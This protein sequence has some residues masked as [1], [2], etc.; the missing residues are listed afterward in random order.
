MN[1]LYL[2]IGSDKAGTVSIANMVN[3][4]KELLYK[5][6]I[7]SPTRNCLYLFDYLESKNKIHKRKIFTENVE[8][9][10]LETENF[11]SKYRYNSLNNM[12]ILLTTE[13]LWGRLSKNR[14]HDMDKLNIYLNSIKN[15][16]INH[17]IIIILNLRRI[18]LY[19]ES[20]YKQSIK[21]GNNIDI[22]KISNKISPDNAFNFFNAI[23]KVFSKNN[24]LVRP[25]EKNQMYNKDVV[26]DILYIMGLHNNIN[27]FN[28]IHGNEGLHR[29]LLETLRITNEKY[30][31]LL[32]NIDLINI[33]KKLYKE[34]EFTDYKYILNQ[35]S[36]TKLIEQWK[37]F[38]N[39]IETNYN[40]NKLFNDP[41]PEDTHVQYEL[42][43]NKYEIIV[44]LMLN[45]AKV[46]S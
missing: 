38:Y 35:E 11:M 22:N 27:D 21:S 41:L 37:N 6:N 28:I 20:L 19:I 45:E 33:S 15:L 9:R 2:R 5:N 18:D 16:F 1:K 25:F 29:D 32:N 24:I 43:K 14:I 13:V 44:N 26:S 34:Y 39:Y 7:F 23:E 36:R 31:K 4:N 17:E 40:T 3:N 12:D 10:K 42:D 46:Q 30:G 8:K